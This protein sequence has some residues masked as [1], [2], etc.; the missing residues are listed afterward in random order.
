M[1]AASGKAAPSS[2]ATE[3]AIETMADELRGTWS[4]DAR[5]AQLH[6]VSGKGGTGKTTVAA[7]MALALARDGNRVL[8]V[9]VEQRQGIARLFD[10]EPLPYEEVKVAEV[11]GGGE[12][13]ALAIDTEAAMLEYLDMFYKLGTLGK[14]MRA[15]GAIEFATSIAPGIKDVILTGKVKETATR[16]AEKGEVTYDAIVVDSPPTGRIHH[17]LDV[18]TAMAGLAR[19]G[20]IYKQAQ[21]VASL[22]HS[23]RTVVHLVTL[24]ESLPVQETLDAIADLRGV[25]LT[26]GNVVVNRASPRFIS[27]EDLE[28]FAADGPDPSELAQGLAAAELV[29][30]EGSL[31]DDRDRELVEGLI[32]QA[33][34]HARVA[35]GQIAA[36]EGLREADVDTLVLPHLNSGIDPGALFDL[37]GMLSAQEVS[38]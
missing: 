37:A 24:L 26:V 34:E 33:M 29:P 4:A 22:L 13:V 12:V 5:K 27:P 36:A 7:A 11:P 3:P 17:F 18:T 20:P 35:Q 16:K 19:S 31:Y 6:F 21:S 38:K 10:R 25:G 2:A 9:E 15:A 28:R 14:A 8:L 23:R 30:A 32:I 1:S